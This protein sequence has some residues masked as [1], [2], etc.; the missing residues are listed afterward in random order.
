M[1]LCNA[2][3]VRFKLLLGFFRNH[4]SILLAKYA[5]LSC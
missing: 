3:G 4:V 5:A 1:D 2:N